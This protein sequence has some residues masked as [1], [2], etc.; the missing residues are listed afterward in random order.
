MTNRDK[1]EGTLKEKE[2]ELTGDTVREKQ[3][4]AEKTRAEAEE[5]AEDVKEEIDDRM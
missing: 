2:G 4:E 1:I 3:G 5:K